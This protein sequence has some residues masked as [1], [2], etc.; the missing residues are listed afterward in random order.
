MVLLTRQSP[1]AYS[2]VISISTR[3]TTEVLDIGSITG[4][5]GL[6]KQHTFTDE[7]GIPCLRLPCTSTIPYRCPFPHARPAPLAPL[8][9]CPA[10][11]AVQGQAVASLVVQGF[12][13]AARG[14]VLLG[15]TAT[16]SVAGLLIA[17][18]LKDKATLP[19]GHVVYLVA[20]AQWALLPLATMPSPSAVSAEQEFWRALQQYS[21]A[22]AHYFCETADL[23]RPFP[24]AHAPTEA[25][26]EFVWN[27]WLSAPLHALGL[28][29]HCPSLLQ[30]AVEA[31]DELH[32]TG[33]RYTLVLLSR[34][35][36]RHP[37]TRYIARG[38]N[39]FAG[40]G[41][42]IEAEL[43]MWTPSAGAARVLGE[44]SGA[45]TGAVQ[46]ARVAWRR[47]TVPVWWG[48]ELQPL[49][50][51]LQA[52]VYVRE[53]GTFVGMLSYFRTLHEAYSKDARPHGPAQAAAMPLA[54]GGVPQREALAGGSSCSSSSDGG[55]DGRIICIN[56]LHMSDRKAAELMLSMS[57]EEVS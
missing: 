6:A 34:R 19:G 15:F 2:L 9:G 37:G 14:S 42:E 21:V 30:G 13:V 40:P 39:E 56:L 29:S 25:V 57:F 4:Q 16:D 47:G 45:G 38:L 11:T 43:L 50:K 48:V 20:E 10:G 1:L 31:A 53:E 7:V 18:R 5:L 23:T 33:Q 22:G 54:A 44:V 35:S 17:T 49:N 26:P 46:W 36:R 3:G 32:P 27:T 12:E 51:G 24:S 41:N 8:T 52:E 28:S 55:A